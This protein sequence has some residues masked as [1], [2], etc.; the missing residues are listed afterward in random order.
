LKITLSKFGRVIFYSYICI[1]QLNKE[2]MADMFEHYEELPTEVQAILDKYSEMDNTYENC[3]NLVGELETIGWTC[4]YGLSA[5]P[6]DL[7]RLGE[8]SN[9]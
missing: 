6:Y 5:E 1:Y 3:G 7:R 8:P 9:Y 4:E 2:I